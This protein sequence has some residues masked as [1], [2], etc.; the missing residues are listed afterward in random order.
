MG[1]KAKDKGRGHLFKRGATWYLTWREN[2]KYMT[3]RLTDEAGA[4]VTT[5]RE[6]ERARDRMLEHLAIGN[7]QGRVEAILTKHHSL[8]ETARRLDL[9]RN[10]TH[11]DGA[12]EVY[13]TMPKRREASDQTRAA[14]AA[15]WK[16]FAVWMKEHHP[17]IQLVADITKEHAAGYVQTLHAATQSTKK[18]TV[19]TPR[20][21]NAS[22][23]AIRLLLRL[24]RK[25][26]GLGEPNP[27]VDIELKTDKPM[28]RDVLPMD[29]MRK[30]FEAAPGDIKILLCLGFFSGQRLGDCANAQWADFDLTAGLWKFRQR[31]TGA[32]MV[33]P[34]A[35]ELSRLLSTVPE[36]RRQS[37]LLPDVARLYERDYRELTDRIMGTFRAVLGDA[38]YHGGKLSNKRRVRYGFHSLRHAMNT[39]LVER[40]VSTHAVRAL[41]GHTS[42]SMTARYSHVG[43]DALRSAV[44]LLPALA[45]APTLPAGDTA[46][47]PMEAATAET[48]RQDVIRTAHAA[49]T[50]TLRR[51]LAAAGE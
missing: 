51:M 32:E 15:Y 34:L 47:A 26:D 14:Y 31:K 12:F 4:A 43:I 3:R 28:R 20:T 11:L 41:T 30:V 25:H 40:G 23:S 49:D 17:D 42:D 1:T 45:P 5:T 19:I 22:V 13:A 44:A 36:E 39:Y 16:R 46:G 18:E 38:V 8:Q 6:A 35:G 10:G 27:F 37:H 24:V 33:V 48:L 50:A 29:Q 21:Y 9:Q 2:G 7:E